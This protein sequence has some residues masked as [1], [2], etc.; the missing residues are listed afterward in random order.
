MQKNKVRRFGY[1]M[2]TA[3]ALGAVAGPSVGAVFNNASQQVQADTTPSGVTPTDSAVADTKTDRSITLHKYAIT[4]LSQL[5]DRGDGSTDPKIDTTKI[6]PLPG[7]TFKIQKV[8]PIAGK[9]PLVDPDGL[10]EGTDYNL[11]AAP[12]GQTTQVTGDDGT[13]KFDLG[14]GTPVTKDDDGNPVSGGTS[15]DGIYLITEEPS[16]KVAQPAKPFFVYVPQTYRNSA[17]TDANSRL[18]YDVNVYPK[19]MTNG[20]LNPSK[21]IEGQQNYSIKA[22]DVFHWEATMNTP[23]DLYVKSSTS[24]TV[25]KYDFDRDAKGNV[26]QYRVTPTGNFIIS[27]DAWTKATDPQKTLWGAQTET[28]NMFKDNGEP[29]MTTDGGTTPQTKEV[30]VIAR[31]AYA[32]LSQADSPQLVGLTA[33]QNEAASDITEVATPD[34]TG[35]YRAPAYRAQGT[36]TITKGDYVSA[37]EFSIIDTFAPELKLKAEDPFSNSR[38]GTDKHDAANKGFIVQYSD[39]QGKWHDLAAGADYNQT[40]DAN[41]AGYMPDAQAIQTVTADN[42][43][44]SKDT[45]TTDGT[46]VTVSLTTAGM[47]KVA[48]NNGASPDGGGSKQIRVVYAVTAPTDYNG[49]ISNAFDSRYNTPGKPPVTPGTPNEPENPDYPVT[50]TPNY[51]TGGFDL[52]K[53]NNKKY[54]DGGVGLKDAEFKI[55]DSAAHATNMIF[56]AT[57]GKLYQ[58]KDNKA[59]LVTS[60]TDDKGVV[61][62]DIAKDATDGVTFVSAKSDA[63]GKASF[64]GLALDVDGSKTN[65]DIKRTYYFV[66]T[67]APAGF[68]LDKQAHPIDVTLTT[69]DKG[70]FQ[71]KPNKA[72][73]EYNIV[74]KPESNLPFTGGQGMLFLIIIATTLGITGATGVYVAKKK[75]KQN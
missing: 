19:N 44:Q 28:I 69:A 7:I 3:M 49:V 29:A 24:T 59:Y 30:H 6:K 1:L 14:V 18:I 5:G 13:A 23:A 65:A 43:D 21:T 48:T 71:G 42:H 56:Y 45:A 39:D 11:V 17:P 22:G 46:K 20:N 35:L 4:D 33:G 66:E 61:T 26:N 62:D 36:T 47:K 57:D 74:D 38:Y 8:V 73:F 51:Y 75:Q 58:E 40:T 27:D 53:T 15:A 67:K 34:A 50:P 70:S 9:G 63:D 2:L 55:S 10:K 31:D 16:S 25:P 41:A 52:I 72:H 32:K 64:N 12:N 60:T 68:E 37:T 54:D